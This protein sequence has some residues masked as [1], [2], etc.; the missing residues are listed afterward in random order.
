MQTEQREELFMEATT[1]GPARKRVLVLA[2]TFPR[3]TNDTEPPFVYNLSRCLGDGFDVTV[4]AP[5]ALGALLIEAMDGLTVHRFRYFWPVGLQKLAY[6]G[7]LPNL[8]RNRWL[9][10]QVP[11]FLLA[12]FLAARSIVRRE[13]IEVIH[14]HW[15]VPQGVVG[16]LVS[17]VTG[18]PLVV[19]AHGADVYGANGGIKNKLKRWALRR[20]ARVT[21]VSQ[22]LAQA[23][24]RLMGVDTPVEV[25]SMGV[26]TERFHPA[27][28][29]SK[30]RRQL[31][32]GPIVLFVGRLAE[33][34][35]VR[36]L[37]EAMPA[38]LAEAPDAMLVI[39]GDGPLRGELEQQARMLSIADNV[40]FEGAKRPDEL[41][42]YYHAADVFAGPSIVA[43][44]GDTESFGLV[45]AEAMACG[46]P[47]VASDVG[48]IGDLVKNG[49]TGLLVSQRD[50]EALALAICRVLADETLHARLRRGGL[51]HIQTNYTQTAIA[52]RYAELLE[53]VAA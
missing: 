19:T 22:D 10:A 25:I 12:E 16:A 21:A 17:K 23:I 29:P 30:L 41:P 45:F 50:P 33:K 6:G 37:L 51:A 36:Y 44:G 47:V 15:L 26:D 3:W 46:L 42:A 43:E 20:T 28:E 4:L 1:T 14:A 18:K 11:F 34:K 49:E 7:M 48:G 40:R 53:G 31:G 39:V 8:K 27:V 24:D 35:G 2:S 9:W 5:H 13:C 32:G 52:G 38:V